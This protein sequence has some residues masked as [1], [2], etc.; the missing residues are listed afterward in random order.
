VEIS[1]IHALVPEIVVGLAGVLCLALAMARSSR[2]ADWA[3]PAALVGLLSAMIVALT[4]SH[5][6]GRASELVV[7][8]LVAYG[9]AM[10]CGVGAIVVL[11]AWALPAP[12]RIAEMFALLLFSVLGAMLTAAADDLVLLFFALELVS[13]PT[14]AMVAAGSNSSA[15][16]EAGLKYFFL[17]ALSSALTVYGF[18]FLYGA[19]GTTSMLGGIDGASVAAGIQARLSSNPFAWLGIVLAVLGL[20]YKVAAVPM[21]FYVADVYQGAA[22]PVSAMLSYVP[23]FAGLVAMIKILSLVGWPLPGT[24]YALIWLMAAATMTVGNT[25]G[26][27]QD[28][29]KRMLG[30]SS[31]AHS[32]YMLL[33]LLVGPAVLGGTGPLQDGLAAVLFYIVAYGIMNIGAFTVIAYLADEHGQEPQL[34][35]AFTGV[36]RQRPGAAVALT[37]CVFSL[38]GM[39]PTA[40]FFAKVYLFGSTLSLAQSSTL[41]PWTNAL[42]VLAL[43]NTAVSSGYYLR[44]IGAAYI[45]PGEGGP[46]RRASVPVGAA[47]VL[48][49]VLVMVIGLR[50]GRLA[51]PAGQASQAIVIAGQRAVPPPPTLPKSVAQT[52]GTDGAGR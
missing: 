36:G 37:F 26:L 20:A 49:A 29:V 39:P 38:L 14:Y 17:G 5:L 48:C 15:A 30:Y 23:K 27:L 51:G 28:N 1:Y 22:A 43:L 32:G 10:L 16:R 46:W 3:K 41:A 18:S 24:L 2:V 7:D 40:G 4:Q 44:I 12:G 11:S 9:R 6:T 31:V 25:L 42:V 13:V 19:A 34:L 33:G 21:H 47:F 35:Q 50:P 52:I 45:R 8:P